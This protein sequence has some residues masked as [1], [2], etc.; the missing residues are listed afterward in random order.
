MTDPPVT[1]IFRR[2]EDWQT[3][4][5]SLVHIVSSIGLAWA[6]KLLSPGKKVEGE[7]LQGTAKFMASHMFYPP[8]FASQVLG[9]KACATTAQ[10]Y[11]QLF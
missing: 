2:Q 7:H 6:K 11:I 5:I 10:P 9:L 1:S 3:L 4:K 8:A